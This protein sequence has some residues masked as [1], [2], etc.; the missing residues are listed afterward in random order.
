MHTRETCVHRNA[1]RDEGRKVGAEWEKKGVF[2][3]KWGSVLVRFLESKVC[4]GALFW[5]N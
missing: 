5:R 1:V 4:C 3:R 2:S